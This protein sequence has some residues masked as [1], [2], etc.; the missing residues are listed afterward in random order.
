MKTYLAE[1]QQLDTQ[2]QILSEMNS[3][4]VK[5]DLS[6]VHFGVMD[7]IYDEI[8]IIYGGLESLERR[9]TT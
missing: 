4:L 2:N 3:K 9:I 8:T 1:K 7:F 5:P 6:S